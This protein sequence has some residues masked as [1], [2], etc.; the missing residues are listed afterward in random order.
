[1][2]LK[3]AFCWTELSGYMAACWRALEG[4]D[5]CEVLVLA[6]EGNASAPFDASLMAGLHH[7]LLTVS[8]RNDAELIENMLREFGA[9]VL[10]FGGWFHE[11]YVTVSKMPGLARV[12]QVLTIDNPAKFDWRQRLGRFTARSHIDRAAAVVVPGERAFQLMRYW[13]V[14]YGKIHK[15]LYGIDYARFSRV[16]ENRQ[17]DNEKWPHRFLFLG[18]YEE[19]KGVDILIQAYRKYREVISDPWPLTMCGSGSMA[20]LVKTAQ[21]VE[22]LGFIQPNKLAD[23]FA[24]S[25]VFVLPSRFDPWP[26]VIGEAAASGLPVVCTSACGSSAELVR[27]FH[28][29]L[30]MPPAD[31]EALRDA[32]IWS[33]RN[34]ERLRAMGE[35]SQEL[36]AAYSAERWAERWHAV[37]SGLA[38]VRT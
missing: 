13:N 25:G 28:N 3:I 16:M 18:R 20:E 2:A 1:M 34:S 37:C 36:A 7:Q 21:G 8:Q 10:V 11:P 31:I 29:G 22:D 12:P 5:D 32:L 19:I 15:G 27:D 26:L 24:R 6:F 14:P 33:H 9:D 35:R 30:T 17:S 4:R 23:Q 38:P